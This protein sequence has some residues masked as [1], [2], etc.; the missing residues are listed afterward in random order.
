MLLFEVRWLPGTDAGQREVGQR[1]I[2]SC[3][4]MLPELST[5]FEL[6]VAKLSGGSTLGMS[7]GR[8]PRR[9][10]MC[11]QCDGF[12]NEE[13]E[14]QITN[15]IRMYGNAV[16]FIENPDP[17]KTFG[18]TVGLTAHGH[19]EF[20]VRG[21]DMVTTCE[22]LNPLA[23]RVITTGEIFGHQHTA[24][25]LGQQLLYFMRLPDAGAHLLEAV[26]RYGTAMTALEIHIIDSWPPPPE[27][28]AEAARRDGTG[29]GSDTSWWG[30]PSAN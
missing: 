12:S 13:V 30:R 15:T 7:I 10:A 14:L 19:P 22:L 18:Y 16:Q 20:L 6:L 24:H 11:L 3:P 1:S 9:P 25:Y 27:L 8:S 29:C 17:T 26:V 5:N 23:Q 21:L 4:E 2:E 28:L